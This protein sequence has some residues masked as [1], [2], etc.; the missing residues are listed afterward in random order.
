M[1]MCKERN[2]V[3]FA[4][5]C[6]EAEVGVGFPLEIRDVE[7]GIARP[8]ALRLDRCRCRYRH[9]SRHIVSQDQPLRR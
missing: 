7:T 9:Q 1:D 2:E 5:S 4:E 8:V 6:L 3:H